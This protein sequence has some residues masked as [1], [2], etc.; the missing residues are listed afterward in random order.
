MINPAK[1]DSVLQQMTDQQLQVLMR[2]PDKIP[3]QFVVKELN[4]R[5]KMRQQAKAQEAS[6]QQAAGQ[7][8]QMGAE[9]PMQMMGEQ[10]QQPRMMRG[11]GATKLQS[12]T[13]KNFTKEIQEAFGRGDF[14]TLKNI[15]EDANAPAPARQLAE[16]LFA[17]KPLSDDRL[18]TLE[19]FLNP[20][21]PEEV[22]KQQIVQ[23]ADALNLQ[24]AGGALDM[25]DQGF[26][27]KKGTQGMEFLRNLGENVQS[28]L[29]VNKATDEYF[30]EDA[31]Y[32]QARYNVNSPLDIDKYA[33]AAGEKISD[34]AGG[35]TNF[36]VD[37]NP[38]K[39]SKEAQSEK[40][41][42]E[43]N[44]KRQEIEDAEKAST[45]QSS[46]AFESGVQ[47]KPLNEFID[48]TEN[49]LTEKTYS[50][51]SQNNLTNASGVEAPLQ[52]P[53][54]NNKI[55]NNAAE[56]FTGTIVANA[57]ND[58]TATGEVDNASK[59]IKEG[60]ISKDIKNLFDTE[61]TQKLAMDGYEKSNY[62]V[63]AGEMFESLSEDNKK[64]IDLHNE[65]TKDL[66]KQREEMLKMMDS[67]KRSP[68][69]IAF[70]SL[71]DM[72]LSLMASP[73]A[74][75]AQAL[76]KSGQVG[77]QTFRNL[78]Q[79]ERDRLFERY[80]MS[81][82]LSKAERDHQ[83]QGLN[84]AKEFKLNMITGHTKLHQMEQQD[85]NN[86]F[87]RAHTAFNTKINQGKLAIQAQGLESL[88]DYRRASIDIEKKKLEVDKTEAIGKGVPDSVKEAEWYMGL[89]E[90]SK[91]AANQAFK[92]MGTQSGTNSTTLNK[93]IGEVFKLY[94]PGTELFDNLRD[95]LTK[96]LGRPP[97]SA[98]MTTAIMGRSGAITTPDM[99]VNMAN[100]EK[101]NL[102]NK[103]TKKKD[104]GLFFS[105]DI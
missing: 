23:K 77:M 54:Q 22:E 32:N 69:N 80:K 90:N 9:Q 27:I 102:N 39:L 26:D 67:M 73:E 31:N 78:S 2:R 7:P 51:P 16:K 94:A 52:K 49:F 64:I 88:D 59:G 61:F 58:L 25:S 74:N 8:M 40:A 50:G 57:N 13:M 3:T 83:M 43:Y 55:Q 81:W 4:R 97:S 76:G 72:G 70:Q 87:N 92:A 38:F 96:K 66:V 11:G 95:E 91:K 84:L 21:Q 30:D 65:Q 19:Q 47:P 24:T 53:I 89:D 68:E 20:L 85:E 33:A 98:E 60:M 71:I 6:L 36:L 48:L 86:Y 12:G 5:Q 100:D 28:F 79:Q 82:E 29:G 75:F 34:V 104:D 46:Q 41:I 10:Q 18:N 62:L 35:I 45:L 44:Q 37:K 1:Y 17:Q 103:S 14:K 93:V 101:N 42:K 63:K 56:Q 15:M 105:T 99:V